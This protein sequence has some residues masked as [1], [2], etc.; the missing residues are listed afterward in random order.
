M[1]KFTDRLVTVISDAS[2]YSGP[3]NKPVHRVIGAAW[4][5]KSQFITHKSSTHTVLDQKVDSNAGE[6]WGI[7]Q[8][9]A[10]LISKHEK[11]GRMNMVVQCDNLSA[12]ACLSTLG[13][14]WSKNSKTASPLVNPSEAILDILDEIKSMKKGLIYLKHV[15]GHSNI[16]DGR[17]SVNRMV[18]TMAKEARVSGQRQINKKKTK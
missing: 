18:D 9:M 16:R 6:L 8:A 1:S 7:S 15:K 5:Y 3:D 2:L 11:F 4:W 12:L 10:C 14:K 13:A 17:H